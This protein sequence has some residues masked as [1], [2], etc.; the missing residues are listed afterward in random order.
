VLVGVGENSEQNLGTVMLLALDVVIY[1]VFHSFHSFLFSYAYGFQD[2]SIG[3]NDLLKRLYELLASARVGDKF[4]PHLRL[5]LSR[6]SDDVFSFLSNYLV[7]AGKTLKQ[8]PP[9]VF[10]TDH[11]TYGCV[12]FLTIFLV[13][14][15]ICV[16]IFLGFNFLFLLFDF[17]NYFD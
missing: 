8:M 16:V 6:L 12:A 15:R 17:V 3:S 5:L 4:S 9:V 10:E 2:Q 7:S 14:C 13:V 1:L 11:D